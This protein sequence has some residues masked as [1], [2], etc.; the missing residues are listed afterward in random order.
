MAVYLGPVWV[1]TSKSQI[2]DND[3]AS[4]SIVSQNSKGPPQQKSRERELIASFG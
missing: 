4:P 2:E 3:S 1:K